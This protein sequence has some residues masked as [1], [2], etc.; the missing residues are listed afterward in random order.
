VVGRGKE[1][2]K[3]GRKGKT[4]Q[5]KWKEGAKKN[6]MRMKT[7]FCMPLHFSNVWIL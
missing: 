2:G 5:R 1:M 7:A 3:E 6:R 4:G